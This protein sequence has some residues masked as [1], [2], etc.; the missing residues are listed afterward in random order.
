MTKPKNPRKC[1]KQNKVATV[2]FITYY[3]SKKYTFTKRPSS[4]KNYVFIATQNDKAKKRQ[5]KAKNKTNFQQCISSNITIP[6]NIRLQ[7][8]PQALKI[9]F[10]A[11]QND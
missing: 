10:P 3:H 4:I 6:N 7:N 9:M 2:H 5:I 8:D 11:T 1:Q